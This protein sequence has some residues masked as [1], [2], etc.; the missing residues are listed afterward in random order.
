MGSKN[1]KTYRDLFQE[2]YD[3]YGIQTTT[4]FHVDPDKQVS[5]EK[6]QETLKAYSI[7]PA[8]F[9]DTFGRIRNEK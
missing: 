4:Q 2:I 1:V 3:R 9:D 5:E 6:Y 8:I 7:L